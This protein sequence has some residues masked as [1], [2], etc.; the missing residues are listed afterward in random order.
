MDESAAYSTHLQKILDFKIN[1]N[2]I[3]VPLEISMLHCENK[4]L[5]NT[6][7]DS[8]VLVILFIK[9]SLLVIFQ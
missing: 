8:I 4:Y 7:I 3:S 5:R 1:F 6:R 2:K 9:E